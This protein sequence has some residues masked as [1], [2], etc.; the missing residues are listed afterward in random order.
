MK[1]I[2][3]LTVAVALMAAAAFP[4]RL[5]FALKGGA[6]WAGGGDLAG[7]LSGLMDYYS[8]AYSDLTGRHA[9]AALGWALKGEIMVHLGSGWALGLE[10]GYERHGRESLVSYSFGALSASETLS[11][12]LT[13][14]PLIGVG[15]AFLPV[16]KIMLDIQAGAGAFLTRLDW[17]S[18][19]AL[20]ILGYEGVDDFSFSSSRIGFGVQAGASLEWP[21]SPRLALVAG[22]CGRYARISGYQ[23]DWTETG[24]GELWS[25]SETG[26]GRLYAYDWTDGGSTYRQI[27]VQS[28]LPEGSA[29]ANVREAS[30]D[31]TGLTA[32]AGIRIS[33]F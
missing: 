30:I 20:S 15:H 31:L 22:V 33:L 4:Q 9:F 5:S 27:A 8:D 16:G 28:G 7:G 25:F 23:G 19:Y 2:G 1:K 14:I 3:L 17:Q 26:S 13:A 11:P 6:G 21:L 18:S 29:V 24:S 32:T 12:V 10:A